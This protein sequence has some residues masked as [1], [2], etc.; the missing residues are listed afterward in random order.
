MDQIA[1]D[2]DNAETDH[3]AWVAQFRIDYAD[4]ERELSDKFNNDTAQERADR[5][6]AYEADLEAAIAHATKMDDNTIYEVCTKIDQ[7]GEGDIPVQIEAV[8]A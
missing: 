6:N 7:E 3:A 1:I 5:E 4:L 8:D 2:L